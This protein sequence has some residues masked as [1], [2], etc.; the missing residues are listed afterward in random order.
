MVITSRYTPLQ[1]TS[2]IVTQL[3]GLAVFNYLVPLHSTKSFQSIDFFLAEVVHL[4]SI[5]DDIL[6]VLKWLAVAA[7]W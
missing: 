2:K 7:I 5:R 4:I 6:M 3:R 1:S